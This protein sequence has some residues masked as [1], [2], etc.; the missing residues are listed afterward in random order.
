MRGSVGSNINRKKLAA[1]YT[2]KPDAP[3]TTST[4]T[5]V[6]PTST[7]ST[8]RQVSS[9]NVTYGG[10]RGGV[11][12]PQP[13]RTVIPPK[14]ERI[15]QGSTNINA[16]GIVLPGLGRFAAREST[17]IN[18]SPDNVLEKTT[19][20]Q[21]T[22]LQNRVISAEIDADGNR[23]GK[24]DQN[25]DLPDTMWGVEKFVR[26]IVSPYEQPTQMVK[27][28]SDEIAPELQMVK[29]TGVDLVINPVMETFAG[30]KD[31][32]LT[33][34]DFYW[35]DQLTGID[36]PS[37]PAFLR[38]GGGSGSDIIGG[39]A[40]N[41]GYIADVATHKDTGTI[42]TEKYVDSAARFLE[43]PEY[44]IGSAIGEIPLW[45]IG[46]G[47]AKAAVTIS[48]K[49]AMQSIKIASAT[50]KVPGLKQIKNVVQ[51]ERAFAKTE[52]AVEKAARNITNDRT[53]IL[54][55]GFEKAISGALK[56]IK[57]DQDIKPLARIKDAGATI[58][59]IEKTKKIA[60]RELSTLRKQQK[61][62]PSKGLQIQIKEKQRLVQS[63]DKRI[64][65]K[66]N[67]ITKTVDNL[68]ATKLK[69]EFK[70]LSSDKSKVGK[71]KLFE[72]TKDKVQP[73]ITR[74]FEELPNQVDALKNTRVKY[75][76]AKQDEILI[77]AKKITGK[78]TLASDFWVDRS[79]VFPA[80]VGGS[81]TN[82]SNK[83]KMKLLKLKN[84][85]LDLGDD[86]VKTSDTGYV[87]WGKTMNKIDNMPGQISGKWNNLIGTRASRMGDSAGIMNDKVRSGASGQ[88]RKLYSFHA[89]NIN[90]ARSTEVNYWADQLSNKFADI[91]YT[92]SKDIDTM[93]TNMGY[94]QNNLTHDRS[95]L[96]KESD[97][98]EK[99]LDKSNPFNDR[100]N[101]KHQKRLDEIIVETTKLDEISTGIKEYNM[102]DMSG[103]ISGSGKTKESFYFE[104]TFLKGY[105]GKE[106]F[107]EMVPKEITYVKRPV[108]SVEKK[109]GRI[110]ATLGSNAI[111]EQMEIVIQRTP[112]PQA[113]KLKNIARRMKPQI[114]GVRLRDRYMTVDNT[115]MMYSQ[116][117][118]NPTGESVLRVPKN[119]PDTLREQLKTAYVT[120][121]EL[122]NPKNPNMKM[123]KGLTGGDSYDYYQIQP[124]SIEQRIGVN[125]ID[126]GD[127]IKFS[128][129]DKNLN[130]T[131]QLKDVEATRAYLLG[132]EGDL[133]ISLST[134]KQNIS[135]YDKEIDT[136]KLKKKDSQS[137]EH[138]FKIKE[139][140]AS[141]KSMK[142]SEVKRSDELSDT[143]ARIESK[144]ELFGTTGVS[145]GNKRGVVGI[146]DP[147]TMTR[148][149]DTGYTNVVRN[150]KTEQLYMFGE[151]GGKPK[152][153]EI[154]N[155]QV[156]GRIRPDEL[157]YG[158]K[159]PDSFYGL[160]P[161][162]NQKNV[163]KATRQPDDTPLET[164]PKSWELDLTEGMN[165]QYIH[166]EGAKTGTKPGINKLSNEVKDQF[167]IRL[168][169]DDKYEL[170]RKGVRELSP[171]EVSA[172]ESGSSFSTVMGNLKRG[173][174]D[175]KDS[176]DTI[177]PKDDGTT[178]A[179]KSLQKQIKDT[180]KA[181][182]SKF[183]IEKIGQTS[184]N[185]RNLKNVFSEPEWVNVS[186]PSMKIGE[187][188]IQ[189]ASKGIYE[190]GL[191]D[192]SL[193]Q[194]RI[195]SDGGPRIFGQGDDMVQSS[196]SFNPYKLGD[197]GND[198][199]GLDI[200]NIVDLGVIGGR[201]TEE[202]S[203]KRLKRTLQNQ[204]YS[205]YMASA[206]DKNKYEELL[207]AAKEGG[208]EQTFRIQLLEAHRVVANTAG[209]K[210]KPYTNAEIQKI[211]PLSPTKQHIETPEFARIRQEV[212]DGDML[213]EI[214]LKDR[215]RVVKK[216]SK[217][218]E[219]TVANRAGVIS[220]KYNFGRLSE[221]LPNHSLV[222]RTQDRVISKFQTTDD[223]LSNQNNLLGGFWNQARHR[224]IA[225][226]TAKRI[227]EDRF[228]RE[229]FIQA[230]EFA[231]SKGVKIDREYYRQYNRVKGKVDSMDTSM[232]L[233]ER[234]QNI[235]GENESMMAGTYRTGAYTQAVLSTGEKTKLSNVNNKLLTLAHGDKDALEK[236]DLNV[237]FE[238]KGE[239][240]QLNMMDK[241][242]PSNHKEQRIHNAIIELSLEKSG[243][244]R[245]AI[246]SSEYSSYWHITN[247]LRSAKEKIEGGNRNH[248]S[249]M[250]KFS[251]SEME[252]LDKLESNIQWIKERKGMPVGTSMDAS[253]QGS[254]TGTDYF[255]TISPDSKGT[256]KK[257]ITLSNLSGKSLEDAGIL[258]TLEDTVL[259]SV[260]GYGNISKNK[261]TSDQRIGAWNEAKNLRGLNDEM[262]INDDS[263]ISLLEMSDWKVTS[264]DNTINNINKVTKGDTTKYYYA[265]PFKASDKRGINDLTDWNNAKQSDR[266][267]V[268]RDAGYD[269]S[270]TMAAQEFRFN[271]MNNLK[272]SE[273]RATL[274]M[275]PLAGQ[276]IDGLKKYRASAKKISM[277]SEPEK[278]KMR[279]EADR[280]NLL[281]KPP[282]DYESTME[283][284][285]AIPGSK[286]KLTKTD[287][288][289]LEYQTSNID[290]PTKTPSTT[291]QIV[292]EEMKVSMLKKMGIDQK[293]YSNTNT[294]IS[295]LQGKQKSAKAIR[296][297]LFTLNNP[298]STPSQ[299]K[300]AQSNITKEKKASAGY[301][302][303][304][305]SYQKAIQTQSRK[306]TA[307]A[308]RPVNIGK[309]NTKFLSFS[310]D[311]LAPNYLDQTRGGFNMPIA[312]GS[313][314]PFG[315]NVTPQTAY[316]Q[317]QTQTQQTAQPS[318]ESKSVMK[319]VQ[320]QSQQPGVNIM[321]DI[322]PGIGLGLPGLMSAMNTN[323]R[324]QPKQETRL[325]ANL[326]WL[327]AQLPGQI[328]RPN[329]RADSITSNIGIMKMGSTTALQQRS[330]T[331]LKMAQAWRLQT[332]TGINPKKKFK[333][334]R[335]QYTQQR[336]RTQMITPMVFGGVPWETAQDK[337]KKRRKKPKR[338][339]KKTI[340]QT[341]DNWYDSNYWGKDGTGAGYV[342]FKGAEPTRFKDKKNQFG[343]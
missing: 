198:N 125:P 98:I 291:G 145:F 128:N 188:S 310:S 192:L 206:S 64:L 173:I 255:Y 97:K 300:S 237:R 247:E 23:T 159:T 223:F 92:S 95:K 275:D 234:N 143:L 130:R 329:T 54:P 313:T 87:P 338:K 179:S 24:W 314:M 294:I 175:I 217:I 63:L 105:L 168:G 121:M 270:D 301:T 9:T 18:P 153:F 112:P 269:V 83:D 213:R 77:K 216:R 191:D 205:R 104:P 144:K 232:N 152:M 323:T 292:I 101:P 266:Q 35:P 242:V 282:T 1:K 302:S 317:T 117:K 183:A 66:K 79:N 177:K 236:L 226:K 196:T 96:L 286:G 60:A 199:T 127:S 200:F 110:V 190:L 118:F 288:K 151:V 85:H 7:P 8:A 13:R 187:D 341:P 78:A 295:L 308:S 306:T 186:Q 221:K 16:A 343:F 293:A 222:S 178:K 326:G 49:A 140:I 36:H 52:S 243:I 211:L 280:L 289:T 248:F 219:Q 114:P 321:T 342:T 312:Y 209:G 99:K 298:K 42:L 57:Q 230:V 37:M 305:N 304:I 208:G 39:L 91:G 69:N 257:T 309:E 132:D 22:D 264:P 163:V 19:V 61:A 93:K 136:L 90:L 260:P 135:K 225:P 162:L 44:Y 146:I 113:G 276:T 195:I 158:T 256:K 297:N 271:R 139:D 107:A 55:K 182:T 56:I 325:G 214:T 238:H 170:K 193:F 147:K 131:R 46:V 89:D 86:V 290:N 20:R 324:F 72:W 59:V 33:K 67:Y 228:V 204:Q 180:T 148:Q 224:I 239:Q 235:F 334:A 156:L 340:W 320:P 283:I 261:W 330:S 164:N 137:L 17:T 278:K 21:S 68:D 218:K 336:Q 273:P 161:E 203:G 3:K 284:Y 316:A 81:V 103:K 124:L 337:A 274:F 25:K 41:F 84:R 48:S 40:N 265:L 244:E 38:T 215:A 70:L 43:Q 262:S 133:E 126:V 109:K 2:K 150:T 185:I 32:G 29:D 318:T 50:G 119:A 88:L 141:L 220:I 333:P 201:T 80:K 166:F 82:L 47:Q 245:K 75:L 134:V 14:T 252:K 100:E 281:V 11:R 172:F 149:P 251:A 10:G 71:Q 122:D 249:P 212:V 155:M 176:P 229:G 15:V 94:I 76:K 202:V 129:S 233:L 106:A 254:V 296:T 287:I 123:L 120:K 194:R 53:N 102:Y 241:R 277:M 51:T 108:V 115:V 6:R 267:A 335:D 279:I 45:F 142:K 285:T 5:T 197:K 28:F 311:Q 160:D 299:K 169:V 167:N 12:R 165:D 26:G 207:F 184:K 240:V 332:E 189:N 27:N 174:S 328:A 74:K 227:Q 65:S 258:E 253:K 4:T 307:R 73:A 30:G 268:Y 331:L 303:S 111:G 154:D 34:R 231:K 272:E 58:K 62:A 263:G 157:E 315:I 171:A 327:S 246:D 259:D 181:M 31:L 319:D 322:S 138:F 210:Q 339:S 116:R 250:S